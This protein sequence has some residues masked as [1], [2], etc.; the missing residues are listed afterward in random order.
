MLSVDSLQ[1]FWHATVAFWHGLTGVAFDALAIALLLHL[2]NLLLRTRAWRNILQAAHP[3]TYVR[4]R[5]IAGAYLAGVG[6]NSIVPARV[7]D[8]MKVYL[9]NRSIEGSSYPTVV[10]SLLAETAFDAVVGVVILAW[11]YSTGTVPHLPALR[12]LAAFEWSFFANHVRILLALLALALIAIGVFFGRIERHVT[13][14]YARVRAGLA[15]LGQPRRYLRSVVSYQAAGWVLRVGSMYWFLE[16]FHIHASVRNALLALIA[17]SVSTALPLTPGGAGTQQALLVYMFRNVAAPSAVLS[18]SVG[19]QFAI[20]AFNAIVGGIVIAVIFRRL[21][22]KAR[23]P[24]V[25]DGS[26]SEPAGGS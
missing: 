3:R 8:V 26:R 5:P 2:G 18:F 4:W 7:G 20:T 11:A 24:T 13:A 9:A 15:I 17:G 19:M 14:F 23:V 10:S 12:H 22:W 25:A 1:S 21:P 6:A 16:A